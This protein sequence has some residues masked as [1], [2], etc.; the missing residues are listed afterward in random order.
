MPEKYRR[1]VAY[2]LGWLNYFG[3]IFT[4]AGC[5]AV[6]ATLI[7]SLINLC[8]PDVAVTTRWQ[9]FLLYMAV[10]TTCWAINLRGLKSIPTLELLGCWSI[11]LSHPYLPPALK[12]RNAHPTEFLSTKEL[13]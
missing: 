11:P 2:P 7:M 13:T 6:V 12:K 5:C 1:Q 3:W 9:L 10:V 8:N 4:H